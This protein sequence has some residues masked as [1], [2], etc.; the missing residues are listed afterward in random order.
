MRTN[1]EDQSSAIMTKVGRI[2][3]T[4]TG[5]HPRGTSF[6]LKH[7][8]RSVDKILAMVGPV[9][10]P[11]DNILVLMSVSSITSVPYELIEFGGYER[12][13]NRVCKHKGPPPEPMVCSST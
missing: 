11:Q 3:H 2:T 9:D 5:Q 12:C 1:L 10:A 13:S 7:T 4:S 6:G 8:V